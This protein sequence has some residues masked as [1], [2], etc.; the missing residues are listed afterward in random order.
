MAE[1]NLYLKFAGAPLVSL[2]LLPI[3]SKP[4]QHGTVHSH[5]QACEFRNARMAILFLYIG[6]AFAFIGFA[7]SCSVLKARWNSVRVQG[8]VIGYSTGPGQSSKSPVF[9]PVIE[10]RGLDHQTRYVESPIGYPHPHHAP[11][12][13]FPVYL[14]RDEPS[15]ASVQSAVAIFG[16]GILAA[17]GIG[18]V[19]LFFHIFSTDLFSLASAAFITF[20]IAKKIWKTRRKVPLSWEEWLKVKKSAKKTRVYPSEEKEAIPWAEPESVAVA[21]RRTRTSSRVSI[22][23]CLALGL[24]ALALSHHLLVKTEAFLATA[25][26]AEGRIAEFEHRFDSDGSLYT[27]I[28]EFVVPGSAEAVRFKHSVS[29][30]HPSYRAG[31]K[32]T[33]LFDPDHPKT[34]RIDAGIWNYF[35]PGLSGV[36]GGLFVWLA[37]QSWIAY[38]RL[39][40]S[41]RT[42]LPL[43]HR[44]KHSA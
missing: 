16:G 3:S 5:L 28:V 15:A 21:F 18:A 12:T 31:D 2:E 37:L 10:Y 32:V 38:A 29:S 43:P 30:S 41:S 44:P 4:S 42:A 36:A 17:M 27:P 13:R 8:K 40:R 14:R 23:V 19:V 11:G 33:V 25:H 1:V 26:R 24:G 35:F 39:V 34:A 9:H 20:M 6:A 22:P 7:I